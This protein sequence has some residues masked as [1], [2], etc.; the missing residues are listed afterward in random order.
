MNGEVTPLR[1]AAVTYR[2]R[3]FLRIYPP[4]NPTHFASILRGAERTGRPRDSHLTAYLRNGEG[5]WEVYF[6]EPVEAP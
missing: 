5:C 6:R 4:I 1:P 3:V 2:E